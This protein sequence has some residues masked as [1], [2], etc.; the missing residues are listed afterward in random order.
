ME[1]NYSI[2][3][4]LKSRWSPRGF[5]TQAI[6]TEKLRSLFEAARWSPSGGNS[7]PWSFIVVSAV[8]EER[9]DK[10]VHVLGERN[11]FWAKHAPVLVLSVAQTTRADGKHNAYAMY[12]LGQAVAHLSIQATAAGLVVRQMGGFDKERARALFEIPAGFEP[13][14][15]IAIGYHC[16]VQ[17]L[18]EDMHV[19]AEA[20]TR[21]P[22]SEFV[23]EGHWRQP[24]EEREL[25]SVK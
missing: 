11:Q 17:H 21:K 24:L 1:G 15:V 20:R 19:R 12:D 10:F 3:H 14:T 23:F 25:A 16:D 9:H 7:Q 18:P 5:A 22:L 8:D 13:A 6:E 4:L 2:H